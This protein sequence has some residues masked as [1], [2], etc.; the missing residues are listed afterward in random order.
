[1]IDLAL[2][3]KRFTQATTNYP[4]VAKTIKQ[5]ERIITVN[6]HEVDLDTPKCDCHDYKFNG[7]NTPCYHMFVALIYINSKKYDRGG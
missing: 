5:N 1:M 7:K 3:E 2:V 4:E 6:N